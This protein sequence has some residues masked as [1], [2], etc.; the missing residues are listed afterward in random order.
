MFFNWLLL[1]ALILLSLTHSSNANE[2]SHGALRKNMIYE[3]VTNFGAVDYE[4]S[5]NLISPQCKRDLKRLYDESKQLSPWALKMLDASG[6]AGSGVLN[7][8]I[9]SLG[10]LDQCINIGFEDPLAK[11]D[12]VT[13]IKADHNITGMF[14]IATIYV[15]PTDEIFANETLRLLFNRA[16]SYHSIR[17][18]Y[19]KHEN[20]F[21]LSTSSISKGLCLPGSCD[22]Q[23]VFH[24]LEYS[25]QDYNSSG[26]IT[27]VRID[28][29]SCQRKQDLDELNFSI[30]FKLLF[31]LAV[32]V[33][34]AIVATILD[35]HDNEQAVST[36]GQRQHEGAA[37][38]FLL[39]FSLRRTWPQLLDT[40]F[41]PGEITCLHGIRCVGLIIVYVQHKVFFRLFNM[42][43]NRTDMVL[44]GSNS[45]SSP[46]R[47]MYTG[48]D[49]FIFLSAAL[50]SYYATQKLAKTGRLNW[51]QMILSRYIKFTPTVIAFSWINRYMFVNMH[52]SHYFRIGHFFALSCQN[53]WRFLFNCFHVQNLMLGLGQICAP[54]S[55]SLATDMQH[56][57]LAPF[58]V[59]LLWKLRKNKSN[60]IIMS[61]LIVLALTLYK[62]YTVYTNGLTSFALFGLTVEERRRSLN[63]LSINP[64]QQFTTYFLGLLFGA[65]IQR[66]KHVILTRVQKL[67]GWVIFFICM[68]YATFRLSHASYPGYQYEVW[69]HT[70]YS[71][72]RPLVFCLALGYLIYMCHTG[73]AEFL[74]RLLSWH[75][76][77]IFSK[78]SFAFYL[79]SVLM[80]LWFMQNADYSLTF[81]TKL[82]VMVDLNEIASILICSILSTLL[83][84]MPLKDISPLILGTKKSTE[85]KT[86]QDEDTNEKETGQE[87]S[88]RKTN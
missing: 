82:S 26:L 51:K 49:I 23:D 34:I 79:F 30:R 75:Y 28:E 47:S 55:H 3:F 62:G 39:A 84:I 78:I 72:I 85:Q 5:S 18:S 48:T 71:M 29:N 11:A 16:F 54:Q 76:F 45:D 61:S 68:R 24:L 57:I 36:T 69:E 50:T 6:K 56:Y 60:L 9:H 7:G 52:T 33:T 86:K 8:N 63:L 87:I 64:I 70:E 10:Y 80:I 20:G 14:C 42:I 31:P 67:I 66:G 65:F 81:F 77:V 73:Q 19:H 83:L 41:Q 32:L 58:V 53:N 27:R 17:S 1:T 25:Y 74:N 21:M 44:A 46:I 38:T 22:Y 12:A 2:S 88:E 43:A 59:M 4:P 40:S 13:E 35:S 37:K 15:E